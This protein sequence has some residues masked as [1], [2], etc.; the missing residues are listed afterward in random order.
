M[1]SLI[2]IIFLFHF[3]SSLFGNAEG[4]V[5]F[6]VL[7]FG[8]KPDGKSDATQPFF[9]AWASACTSSVSSIIYVPKGRYLIKSSEF[10]GPCKSSIKVQIDGT[11]IAPMD[12]RVIGN[13]DYWI[14]FI[15]VNQLSVIGGSLD[16]NGAG[17]WQCKT[18]GQ[19]CPSGA[20]VRT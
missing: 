15:Q 8:A 14:L 10:R 17:L 16:A 9:R 12:Y 6:N 18:S 2:P 3:L 19:S 4:A 20:R 7:N 5:T 11:L 13:P 1:V